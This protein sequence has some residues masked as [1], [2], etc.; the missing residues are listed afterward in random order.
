MMRGT[1]GAMRLLVMEVGEELYE[2]VMDLGRVEALA[3]RAKRNKNRTAVV[4]SGVLTV[5]RL[6]G[7]GPR[8]RR[9]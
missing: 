2:V 3:W 1:K 6:R 8:A 7:G 4:G 9:T 5:R